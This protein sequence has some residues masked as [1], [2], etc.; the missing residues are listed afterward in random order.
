MLNKTFDDCLLYDIAWLLKRRE[1]AYPGTGRGKD[2]EWGGLDFWIGPLLVK[3]VSSNIYVL[4][5]AYF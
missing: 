3:I 5:I 2:K 1:E 4:I